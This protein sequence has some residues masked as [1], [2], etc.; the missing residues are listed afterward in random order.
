MPQCIFDFE[1]SR[2]GKSISVRESQML[3]LQCKIG[4]GTLHVHCTVF[5]NVVIYEQEIWSQ[6]KVYMN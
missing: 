3:H 6:T 2:L 4:V 1:L 5:A